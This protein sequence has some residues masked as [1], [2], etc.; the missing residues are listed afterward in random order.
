MYCD[1]CQGLGNIVCSSCNG[2][3]KK[4]QY[5]EVKSECFTHT[6]TDS[7][8]NG[9]LMKNYLSLLTGQQVEW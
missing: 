9:G 4:K 7:T 6:L 2:K 3:G 8:E 5:I 1:N